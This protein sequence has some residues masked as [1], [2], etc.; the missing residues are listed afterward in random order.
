MTTTKTPTPLLTVE[1]LAARWGVSEDVVREHVKHDGLPFVPLGRGG[2]RPT[3]RF[4]L[5]AVEAWEGDRE[6][7]HEGKQDTPAPPPPSVAEAWDG[8][9]RL[10]GVG[11]KRRKGKK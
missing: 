1:D 3:Y 9:D 2:K 5:A 8:V 4:R 6:R 10:K 7:R 11:G